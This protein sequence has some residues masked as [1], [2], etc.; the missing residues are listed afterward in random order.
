MMR[1]NRFLSSMALAGILLTGCGSEAETLDDAQAS[2]VDPAG[3]SAESGNLDE[4]LAAEPVLAD[5]EI[6]TQL[7]NPMQDGPLA[8]RSDCGGLEGE[9]EFRAELARIAEG[10][11]KAGLLALVSD[12]V[13]LDFGGGAGRASLDGLL[14]GDE[15]EKLWIALDVLLPLGCAAQG[16]DALV[17]PWFF[18]QNSWVDDPIDG[19][20]VTGQNVPFF[21]TASGIAEEFDQISWEAVELI[22]EDDDYPDMTL[23]RRRDGLEGYVKNTSL[24]RSIDYRVLADKSENGWKITAFIAGD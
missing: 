14:S 13:K 5:P 3:D 22:M 24:R 7:L 12:D 4:A 17:L 2:Q 6:L 1:R 9:Q 20:L 18:A 11:D 15:A 23:V 10:R 21:E 16:G 19:Y 8:P